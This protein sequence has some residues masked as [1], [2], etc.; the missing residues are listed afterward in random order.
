MMVIQRTSVFIDKIVVTLNL[1][2]AMN[3]QVRDDMLDIVTNHI[4]VTTDYRRNDLYIHRYKIA[5]DL[6]K[7]E[8]TVKIWFGPTMPNRPFLRFEWNPAKLGPAVSAHL[9]AWLSPYIPR[10]YAV[11]QAAHISRLDVSVDLRGVSISQLLAFGRDAR[12]H[13]TVHQNNDASLTG[14]YLGSRK[15]DFYLLVYDKVEEQRRRGL[16]SDEDG[17]PYQ[18]PVTRVEFVLRNLGVYGSTTEE[19]V[20]KRLSSVKLVD[21]QNLYRANF[22]PSNFLKDCRRLGLQSTIASIQSR[23]RRRNIAAQIEATCKPEWDTKYSF[24]TEVRNKLPIIMLRTAPRSI[25][26]LAWP[27]A[28]Q[29]LR[30]FPRPSKHAN[31]VQI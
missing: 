2:G 21:A 18:R 20:Y 29:N 17:R 16:T 31:A 19:L 24:M 12:T 30:R 8:K 28:F 27:N 14:Y 23:A 9:M 25:T 22:L 15:S 10:Y 7:P 11:W 1:D 4:G 26:I 6:A 5:F 3:N 13:Y